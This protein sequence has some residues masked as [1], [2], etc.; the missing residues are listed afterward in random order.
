[1]RKA[2]QKVA[3]KCS[4][5]K[6]FLEISQSSQENICAR[7]SFFIDWN[8]IKKETLTQLFYCKLCE[9]SKNTL[10]CEIVFVTV[11]NPAF[12]LALSLTRVHFRDELE[13]VVHG[14]E[15]KIKF[16]PIRTQEIAGVRV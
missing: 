10:S 16:S 4:V 1:M 15:Q 13:H 11:G 6:V 12:C 14:G 8:F 5:K 3:Y 7:V 2:R 9:I